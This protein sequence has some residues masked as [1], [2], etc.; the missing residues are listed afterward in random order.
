MEGSSS[1]IFL[2]KEG[3][4]STPPANNLIL[5]GITRNVVIDLIKQEN[6]PLRERSIKAQELFTADELFLTGTNT[7]VMPIVE[8]DGC[9]VGGGSP[10]PLSSRL[11][12][13][14]ED[15]TRK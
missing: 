13:V 9:Q 8:V 3:L 15:Y 5:E 2:I 7:E 4:I 11:K 6:I 14:F 12:R 10:G 1:N